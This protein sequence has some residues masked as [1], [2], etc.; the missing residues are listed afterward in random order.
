MDPFV[1][2]RVNLTTAFCNAAV[3]LPSKG[4][5]FLLSSIIKAAWHPQPPAPC[6]TTLVV[7]REDSRQSGGLLTTYIKGGP[8]TPVF[9]Y[10]CN[11][12]SC[13]PLRVGCVTSCEECF[14]AS[15]KAT[16]G[17]SV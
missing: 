2:M 17:G 6:H 3:D 16:L 14:D 4:F 13:H 9:V 12:Y 10:C 1:L 11:L 15:I 8:V 5:Q 7:V